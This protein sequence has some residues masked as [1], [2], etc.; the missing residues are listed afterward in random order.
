MGYKNLEFPRN[1]I[2]LILRAS[3]RKF[4]PRVYLV[5]LKYKINVNFKIKIANSK[6]ISL[7]YFNWNFFFGILEYF[8]IYF[9]NLFSTKKHLLIRYYIN[10]NETSCFQFQ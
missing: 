9:N 8:V 4:I 5:I 10:F 2:T 6:I 3:S 7:K 1:L